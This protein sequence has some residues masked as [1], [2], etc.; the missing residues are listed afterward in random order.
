VEE[1]VRP[2]VTGKKVGIPLEERFGVTVAVA[3]AYVGIGKSRIYELWR[4]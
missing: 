2:E 1:T 4:A 3:S